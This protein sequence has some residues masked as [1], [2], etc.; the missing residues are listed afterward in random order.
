MTKNMSFVLIAVMISSALAVTVTTTVFAYQPIS[1]HV[2]VESSTNQ[3]N[4]NS[5]SNTATQ[6]NTNNGGGNTRG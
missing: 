3:G 1:N 6:T 5:G 2:V 4:T